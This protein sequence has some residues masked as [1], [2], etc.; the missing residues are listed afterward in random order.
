MKKRTK[1]RIRCFTKTLIEFEINT[2]KVR[3]YLAAW[4]RKPFSRESIR[5]MM[6]GL[7]MAKHNPQIFE[8]VISKEEI[9]LN[10]NEEAGMR[11]SVD[12]P[13]AFEG[14]FARNN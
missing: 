3:K 5:Y 2:P 9:E 13:T 1:N 4:C 7:N 6:Y 8:P 10:E 11:A 14:G 12:C